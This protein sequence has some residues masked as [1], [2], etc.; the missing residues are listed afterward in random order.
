[1]V[2]KMI[3]ICDLIYVFLVGK[4]SLVLVKSVASRLETLG[5][6]PYLTTWWEI[7][8][9]VQYCIVRANEDS[10]TGFIHN[11]TVPTCLFRFQSGPANP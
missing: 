9:G 3:S 7:H 4:S 6:C 11:G 10:N 5:R 8:T 1:M 2:Y